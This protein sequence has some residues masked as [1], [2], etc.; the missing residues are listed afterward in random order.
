[1]RKKSRKQLPVVAL[2][3][4]VAFL[5]TACGSSSGGS[6]G[7][8]GNDSSS[9]ADYTELTPGSPDPSEAQAAALQKYIPAALQKDAAGFWNWMRL[10]PNPYANWTPPKAPWQFC[11]SS[12]YQGNSWR[13]E[14]LDATK[15]AWEQLKSQ[16]LVKGSLIVADANN[17]ATQQATQINNMVQQ[18]CQVIFVMQP[19]STGLCQAYDR[20]NSKGVLVISMQ[21]GTSCTS[22]IQVDFAEYAAGA[23]SAQWLVDKLGGKGTVVECKGIPGV[24]ASETRQAAAEKVFA[25]N[26]GIKVD[27]ITSQWT[28]STGKSQ[29]LQYLAT[30]PGQVDG[31][32]D[33]GTCAVP[34]GEALKQAGRPTPWITGFEGGCYWL[35]Q[36]KE[37]GK[38]SIGFPQSGGQASFA[39][40]QIALRM[41]AGQKMK[42]NMILYPLPTID[43][44]TFSQY[45][46]PSYTTSSTCNAQPAGG[47]PMP[48]DF[49]D[50]L[51]TGGKA[52]AEVTSPL[53]SLGSS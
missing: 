33:G 3:L 8:G 45:Y 51:F 4:A 52:P 2:L 46:K 10:G 38:D 35:A 50:Q 39:P 31:V 7:S 40:F 48:S 43:A 21:T 27:S 34:A 41:L 6:N 22:D 5:A 32:W 24:A 1:V 23:T 18:G 36:V 37:S 26:P 9:A 25:A 42:G 28:A 19:P 17:S 44:S 47:E 12:A 49:L 14:G 15:A 29:M 53:L 30:H 13:V 11:Y 16:N 20:A